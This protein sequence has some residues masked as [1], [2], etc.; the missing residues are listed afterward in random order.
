M[1]SAPYY[2]YY[3]DGCEFSEIEIDQIP[4]I[5]R[6][7][8]IPGLHLFWI[9]HLIDSMDIFLYLYIGNHLFVSCA[10]KKFHM[11]PRPQIQLIACGRAA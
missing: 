9:F 2:P 10:G 3:G 6:F 8:K 11:S 5:V 1:N 7:W 4:K